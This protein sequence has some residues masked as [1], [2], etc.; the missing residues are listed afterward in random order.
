MPFTAD[1]WLSVITVIMLALGG[2]IIRLI[3]TTTKTETLIRAHLADER[4]HVALPRA[5]PRGSQP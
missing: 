3:I 1:A 4:A 5:L 2:G